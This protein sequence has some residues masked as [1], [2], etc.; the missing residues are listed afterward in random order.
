MNGWA[1]LATALISAAVSL[2]V[3]LAFRWWERRTVAWK[4]TGEQ[5]RERSGGTETGRIR[6]EI[7][8]HNTGDGDAYDVRFLRC[9]GE[10]L[11]PWETFEAGKVAAGE[12]VRAAFSVTPEMWR[13][14]WVE[15]IFAS[16]PTH[17]NRTSRTGRLYLQ[18]ALATVTTTPKPRER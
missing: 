10:G 4:L 14:C 17:L 18:P 11:E 16:T 2:A 7:E 1:V 8:L 3:A 15:V 12:S 9:N 13:T 6:A 5:R